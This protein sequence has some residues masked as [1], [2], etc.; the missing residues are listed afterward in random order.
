MED[1]DRFIIADDVTLTDRSAEF[2]RLGIE[3]PGAAKVLAAALGSEPDLA[4]EG[5]TTGRW[6]DDDV[7]IAAFGWSGEPAYQIFLPRGRGEEAARSWI[8]VARSAGVEVTTG[9]APALDILRVE[10]GIPAWG[11]ELDPDVFPDEARLAR[12]ISTTKGCYTG[13]EIVARLRSRG[14]VNHLL[15]GLAFDGDEPAAAGTPLTA[16]ERRTGEVTSSVRSPALGAVGLGY[17]RREHAEPGTRLGWEGGTVRVVALPMVDT[18][19]E[20]AGSRT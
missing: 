19:R 10:A 2:D 5:W 18:S 1:L 16:G 20:S 4:D 3:G 8:E 17:A 12:A 11:A 9:V 6:R 14:Q 15:V 13:Q 7:A